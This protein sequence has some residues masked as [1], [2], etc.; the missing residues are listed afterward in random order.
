MKRNFTIIIT[1]I[2]LLFYPKFNFGQAPDLGTT[3]SF[4]LFTAVGAFNNTGASLVNGDIG[5][6]AGAFNGFPV[7]GTVIG[8]IH[9][10]DPTSAQAA[11]DVAIAYGDLSAVPCGAVI[12]STLGSNQI[13][14]PNVYC[15]G[16]AATLNGN[17]I[18]DGQGDPNALFIIK[19][20]GALAT[21]TLSNVMLIN[22]ASICNVY[23]QINGEFD[24]GDGSIFRGTILAN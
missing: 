6:N 14:V 7:P 8:Q 24:L 9:V 3:S 16:A 18:L 1:A 15:I 23:W 2:A 10:A 17:L 4:A 13:L 22:S 11:T 5:T 19:I 20:D 12:G 21:G